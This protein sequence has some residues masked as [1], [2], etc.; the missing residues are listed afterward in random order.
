M[1]GPPEFGGFADV[2]HTGAADA[3]AA[4]L[5]EVRGVEAVGDWKERSFAALEPR[6]GA[7]LLDVGCGTGE[8]ARAL[9]A[10][11]AP[12]GR[13]IG[14]DASEAM[15]VE[16]RRRAA[17]AGETGVEFL[18]S[19][20]RRLELRDDAV[21][22]ARAERVLQH[23]DEPG[24][25]V[26]EIAR[27]VRPGGPVVV[28]EPDWG[29]L[30]VDAED[31]EAGREVADA[32]G[33]RLRSALVGRSLRRLFL[34]AGLTGVSVGARTLVVTDRE[35]AEMLFDLAGA[36]RHA[37]ADGRLQARRA[38]SWLDGVSRADAQGRLLVAMT[39]FMAVGRVSQ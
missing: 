18:R 24:A 26:A 14:V 35:R 23:V 21:D 37:I 22:G 11:V 4:Y 2:D 9:A 7:V 13:V 6:P 29:T 17:A 16:A 38:G 34:D 36:A 15:V 25:V 3:Y 39:A 31:A 10:R 30:V 33:R 19:D 20:A 1:N 8:D 12:G 5:D 28:A 27:T 32:A